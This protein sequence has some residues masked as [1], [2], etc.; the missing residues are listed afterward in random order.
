MTIRT[1]Q[2]VACIVAIAAALTGAAAATAG[3]SGA[4]SGSAV[5][6]AATMPAGQAPTARAAGAAVTVSWPQVTLSTGDAVAGYTVKRYDAT[7]APATV[8]AG[9][10]GTVATTTCTET[11]VPAGT[12]T[13]T[14]TP[15]EQSWTGKESPPG[16][17]VTIVAAA[18]ASA[19]G[20]TTTG[21]G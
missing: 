15:I 6:A 20:T 8:G 11:N 7:G 19:A 2:P 9:C 10:S 21:E 5:G 13:Y 12:W 18:P 3:W 17:Q 4:G 16:N 14:E 1:G